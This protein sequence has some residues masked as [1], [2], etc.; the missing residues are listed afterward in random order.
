MLSP[1]KEKKRKGEV[2]EHCSQNMYWRVEEASFSHC[3]VT[4]HSNMHATKALQCLQK[5]VLASR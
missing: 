1:L 4:A 5:C 2:V 3:V